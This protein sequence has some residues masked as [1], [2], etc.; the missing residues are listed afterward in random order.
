MDHHQGNREFGK[1]SL[2]R[3]SY[4]AVDSWWSM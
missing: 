4:F 2:R 3:M 1:V